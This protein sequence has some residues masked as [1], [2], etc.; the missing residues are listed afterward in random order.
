LKVEPLAINRQFGA[1]IEGAAP[2]PCFDALFR[3][4]YVCAHPVDIFVSVAD[5]FVKVGRYSAST[6][7]PVFQDRKDFVKISLATNGYTDPNDLSPPI[8]MVRRS[9]LAGCK[10]LPLPV[11]AT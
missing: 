8:P 9:D 6:N 5:S 10:V 3:G 2:R 1:S 11:S 4:D 7:I